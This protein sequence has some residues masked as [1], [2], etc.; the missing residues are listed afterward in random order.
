MCV[1]VGGGVIHAG[2]R[3]H[4]HEADRACMRGCLGRLQVFG[5][6]LVTYHQALLQVIMLVTILALNTG[7]R[8]RLYPTPPRP[9]S[10]QAGM[11]QCGP[12]AMACAYPCVYTHPCRACRLMFALKP[13][14]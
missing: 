11:G 6:T 1:L 8:R 3:M 14:P 12:A 10:P 4:A 9:A 5:R 2:P 7:V 13:S